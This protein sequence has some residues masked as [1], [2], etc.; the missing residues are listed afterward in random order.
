ML[1]VK[2]LLNENLGGILGDTQCEMDNSSMLSE[3]KLNI[4]F[5][6][7]LVLSPK[8]LAWY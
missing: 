3:C 8:W 5:S 2:S 1:D 7:Q 6:W 4:K